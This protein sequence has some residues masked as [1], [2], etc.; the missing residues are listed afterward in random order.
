M[1]NWLEKCNH[2][3]TKWETVDIQD[4]NDID[5]INL[6]YVIE[7]LNNIS[8][9]NDVFLT[10]AGTAYYVLSQN[11][12]IKQNQKIVMPG[13]QAEMG[14][15]L[16]ASLGV[17]LA[18]KDLNPILIIGDGS[19]N[20]NIQ[21]LGSLKANDVPSKI[22]LLNNDGY[23]SI[24]N[25]QKNF[26]NN[27]VYGE[28]SATGLFFPDYDLL[29]KSYGIEYYRIE[30]NEAL[31]ETLEKTLNSKKTILYDIKC[32]FYQE[33]Y[34]TLSFRT[35]LQGNK[36]QS[37]LHDMYPFL[38]LDEIDQEMISGLSKNL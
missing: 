7:C 6:Y 21:E 31:Y 12:K 28:S 19:F 26:Y 30:T 25:M 20:S 29:S 17:Y 15:C 1:L 32:K 3:K 24:R 23:L 33:I 5:G 35:D 22:L 10:D 11:L 38:N 34:P 18:N 2:W 16:P 8:L 27:N 37:G 13:S 14:F 4:M 36:I 9:S